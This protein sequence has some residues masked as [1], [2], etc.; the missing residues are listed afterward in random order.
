MKDPNIAPFFVTMYAGLADIAR[1]KGY[2][3]AI[4]GSVI[5]DM[6]LI[7][8]PWT[9]HAVPAEE[10]VA[11]IKAHMHACDFKEL[12]KFQLSATDDSEIE[13]EA[14]REA[15]PTVRPHGR[16][17]WNLYFHHGAK[18]DIS[19]MPVWSVEH[20]LARLADILEKEVDAHMY[21][22]WSY[23]LETGA[24]ETR[25]ATDEAVVYERRELIERIRGI[26]DKGFPQPC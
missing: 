22:N 12:L 23:D 14:K 16:Q 5:T 2:A 1:A 13:R 26:V 21:E 24:W 4:H 10:L 18:L 17:S 9:A 6:D 8:A 3:L 19:V 7:A 20:P 11:V 25:N 15:S